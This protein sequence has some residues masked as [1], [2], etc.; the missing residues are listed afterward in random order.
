MAS[1]GSGA[2]A[3]SLP[4]GLPPRRTAVRPGPMAARRPA[5]PSTLSATAPASCRPATLTQRPPRAT[6]LHWR[7]IFSEKSRAITAEYVPDFANFLVNKPLPQLT[8]RRIPPATGTTGLGNLV[9]EI[10]TSGT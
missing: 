9:P 10:W 7:S 1:S 4:Q 5:P 8:S 6:S 3:A 2:T